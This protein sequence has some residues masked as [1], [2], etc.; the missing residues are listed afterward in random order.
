MYINK[1]FFIKMFSY[2]ITFP[3]NNNSF[4]VTTTLPLN[5]KFNWKSARK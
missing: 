3:L 5:P 1:E 4:K 2:I